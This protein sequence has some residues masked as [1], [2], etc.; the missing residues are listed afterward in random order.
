MFSDC[1]AGWANTGRSDGIYC[2]FLSRMEPCYRVCGRSYT[3]CV[4]AEIMQLSVFPVCMQHLVRPSCNEK[5]WL[6]DVVR[7]VVHFKYNDGWQHSFVVVIVGRG[8]PKCCR[9]TC[10]LP[11]SSRHAVPLVSTQAPRIWFLSCDAVVYHYLGFL[12]VL[13]Y[14]GFALFSNGLELEGQL[15][16]R[17]LWRYVGSG[18]VVPCINIGTG[19]C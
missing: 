7:P 13:A 14:H 2:E 4:L 15:S 18:G 6:R 10:P 5:F 17:S 12:Q 1:V 11:L 9:P 3:Y 8:K 19:W 16:L